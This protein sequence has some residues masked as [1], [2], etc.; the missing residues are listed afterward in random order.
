M[1]YAVLA[2]A[3]TLLVM[4]SADVRTSFR[5]IIFSAG[6]I[7]FT[8]GT[9]GVVIGDIHCLIGTRRGRHRWDGWERDH[10]PRGY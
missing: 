7:V 1:K 6:A 3:G 4:G 10:S 8:I 9:L 5:S 2:V